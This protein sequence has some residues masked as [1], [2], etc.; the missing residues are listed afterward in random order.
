MS[1]D[2][3]G[4]LSIKPARD[5]LAQR[6]QARGTKPSRTAPAKPTRPAPPAVSANTAPLWALLIFVAMCVGAGG[7]YL[8]DKVEHLQA[9]LSKSTDALT[10]SE[11]ALSSLRQ[12]LENRDKTLSKSGDQMTADIKELNSEVRKLWDVSN[13]RNKAALDE[14]GA[15]IARLQGDLK[16]QAANLDKKFDAAT[17]SAASLK[18][19]LQALKDSSNTLAGAIE[20]QRTELAKL[21]SQMATPNDLEDRITNLEIAIKSVDAYRKQVNTRLDQMDQQIGQLYRKS[22]PK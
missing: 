19:D 6:Q 1:H 13:K 18:D 12:S 8:W 15:A 21:K 7:W 4:D 10:S 11:Q 16:T 22:A 17:S 3:L 5:E 9:S 14:Q 2:P 20:Q